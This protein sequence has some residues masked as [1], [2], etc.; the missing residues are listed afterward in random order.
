MT[1][2][3]VEYEQAVSTY[4]FY[5]EYRMKVLNYT[6]VL[7]GA[8]IVIASE[9]LNTIIGKLMVASL[10]IV[11]T[12]LMLGIEIRTINFAN[13]VWESIVKIEDTLGY[14]FMTILHKR[15]KTK[16]ITQ[17]IYIWVFYIVLCI[18]WFLY[19]GVVFFGESTP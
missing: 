4:R 11:L 17:R 19:M 13:N 12:L 10:A 3:T 18:L 8:L 2:K 7:N 1:D 5:H 14:E 6:I 9:H 15:A 16:G